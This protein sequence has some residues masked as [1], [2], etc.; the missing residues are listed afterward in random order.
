MQQAIGSRNTLFN[1]FITFEFLRLYSRTDVQS[2]FKWNSSKDYIHSREENY[3]LV[4]L[5]LVDDMLC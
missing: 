2:I 1:G 3:I 5:I 4:I